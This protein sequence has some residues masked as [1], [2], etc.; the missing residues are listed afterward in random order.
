MQVANHLYR[1]ENA[2]RMRLIRKQK[3]AVKRMPVLREDYLRGYLS[4]LSSITLDTLPGL[5]EMSQLLVFQPV[6]YNLPVTPIL[7]PD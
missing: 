6:R 4:L 3:L 1:Y 5:V 2:A 7:A